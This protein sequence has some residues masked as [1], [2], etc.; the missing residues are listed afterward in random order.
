MQLT[1]PER[2]IAYVNCG[3]ELQLQRRLPA[4][5]LARGEV[6]DKSLNILDLDGLSLSFVTHNTAQKV[7]RE[8]ITTIQSHYPE[9]MGKMMI[10][11]AP[12][13]FS[14]AWSVMKPLLDEKTVSKISIVG[15]D[16]ESYSQTLLEL[17]DADQLPAL[18][19][20][21]CLCDG[22]DPLSCMMSDKGPWVDPEILEF[23]DTHPFAEVLTPTGCRALMEKRARLEPGVPL[24]KEDGSDDTALGLDVSASSTAATGSQEAA[25]SD[26]S[27]HRPQDSMDEPA[28][29]EPAEHPEIREAEQAVLDMVAKYQ[30]LEELHKTTLVE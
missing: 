14:I 3:N 6:I 15:R 9:M 16:K 22:H 17:V 26:E 20:G 13:V 7:C 24:Q 10:I 18:F 30:S 12:R 28:S 4:C 23:L 19:G 8:L 2:L 1:T 11:N 21:K 27:P 29:P 5:S 25:D